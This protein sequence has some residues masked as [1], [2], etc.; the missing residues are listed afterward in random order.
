MVGV[1]GGRRDLDGG[2]VRALPAGVRA[3]EDDRPHRRELVAE[4]AEPAELTAQAGRRERPGVVVAVGGRAAVEGLDGA[5]GRGR[6]G[7]RRRR[8][9][10][11]RRGGRPAPRGGGPPGGRG[12]GPPA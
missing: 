12:G 4:R 1:G 2:P 3:R 9:L 8:R 11:G 5:G 6:G 7:R 10:G